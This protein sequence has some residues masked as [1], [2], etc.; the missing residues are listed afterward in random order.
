MKRNHVLLVIFVVTELLLA[1]CQ[2][3]DDRLYGEVTTIEYPI[4]SVFK[5]INIYNNISVNLKHGHNTRIELTCP[6]KLAE[7]IT[8]TIT[9]DTLIVRNGNNFNLGFSTN[10]PCE[11]T[12]YY[13]TLRSIDFASIGYLKCAVTDSIRGYTPPL[14]TIDTIISDSIQIDTIIDPEYFYLYVTEGSGDIDLTFSCSL[15]KLFFTN[16]TSKIIF[17]G[18]TNYCE[19]YLSSYG[20]LDASRLKSNLLRISNAS[21]NDAYVWATKQGEPVGL[22]AWIFNRGNIYYRGNPSI[23]CERQGEGKLIPLGED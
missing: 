9:G 19:Y 15:A 22:R 14:A 2:K 21:A 16:G 12:I 13:D 17:R 4:E 23:S 11:M 7:K 6:S 20:Q 5:S 3:M 10:Y 1:S 8:Y 18:K